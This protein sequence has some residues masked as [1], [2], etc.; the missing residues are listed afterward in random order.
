VLAGLVARSARE[1]ESILEASAAA[2]KE[3]GETSS[4]SN[5]QVST[6]G[7]LAT[8]RRDLA[9]SNFGNSPQGRAGDRPNPI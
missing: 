1:E 9:R 7:E 6:R 3:D 2:L 4:D 5:L 8:I